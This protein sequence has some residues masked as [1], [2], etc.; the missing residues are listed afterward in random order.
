VE[1]AMEDVKA[2][3]IKDMYEAS[4]KQFGEFGT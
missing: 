3:V 2:Q 1:Q 4:K